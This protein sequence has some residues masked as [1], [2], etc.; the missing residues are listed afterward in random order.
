M[1]AK[2]LLLS[3]AITL[4]YF[5]FARAEETIWTAEVAVTNASGGRTMTTASFMPERAL[6]V[7]IDLENLGS[8]TLTI[9]PQSKDDSANPRKYSSALFNIDQ[10]VILENQ[11]SRVTR[12]IYSTSLP[13]TF[14]KEILLLKSP[15][16]TVSVTLSESGEKK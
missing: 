3:A 11:G 6:T 10:P 12:G 14:G 9:L 4:C 15:A 2:I 7:P 16:T 13:L 8:C 5:N 1:T